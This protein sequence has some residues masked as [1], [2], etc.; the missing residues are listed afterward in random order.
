[1]LYKSFVGVISV[2]LWMLVFLPGLTIS[3]AP[4]RQQLISGHL[5]WTNVLMTLITYTVTNVAILCCLSGIIGA[6]SKVI[7]GGTRK[8]AK[9]GESDSM[10]GLLLAG[11]LRS[12]LIYLLFIS[13]VYLATNAP[14]ASPT[15]E[16]YVRVAGL[17]SLFA[18]FA[19]YDPRFF[20][21]IVESFA[22]T[23]PQQHAKS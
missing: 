1:M 6:A 14:F 3:S 17:I 19:G 12:F 20:G 2:L 18:F 9:S 22:S 23:A 15:Q 10:S 4:F 16:Q 21:R 5:T 8:E 13:G 11:V 7:I